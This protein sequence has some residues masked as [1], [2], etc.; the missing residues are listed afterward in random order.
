MRILRTIRD[1][2][3]EKCL[4]IASFLGLYDVWETDIFD[5]AF[6]DLCKM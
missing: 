6:D 2:F 3:M 1:V 5:D 4:T